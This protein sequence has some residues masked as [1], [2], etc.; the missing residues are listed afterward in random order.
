MSRT[1][2]QWWLE[3]WVH[4]HAQP[5]PEPP[6]FTTIGWRLVHI[7]DCRVVHHEWGSGR[8]G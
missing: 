6:P 5:D 3:A 8:A 1:S 2:L 7:A 4:D